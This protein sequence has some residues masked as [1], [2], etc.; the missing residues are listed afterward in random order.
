MISDGPSMTIGEY[1]LTEELSSGEIWQGINMKTNL[2]VAIKVEEVWT[3]KSKLFHEFKVYQ[4][5]LKDNVGLN[6]GIPNVYYVD[7]DGDFNYLVMD[8]LGPNLEDLFNRCQRK[9]SLK[10]VLMLADQML[11]RIEYLHNKKYIHRDIKPEN[12]VIGIGETSHVIHMID[13]GLA[14]RYIKKDGKHI[15]FRDDGDFIGTPRYGSINVHFGMT[16]GRRDDLQSL[17]YVLMYFLRGSLP[18]QNIQADE[19]HSKIHNIFRQKYCIIQVEDLCQGYPSEFATYLNYVRNLYF[20]VTPNYSY[21]RKLFKDLFKKSGF[22]M[23]YI[24]DWDLISLQDKEKN[25]YHASAYKDNTNENPGFINKVEDNSIWRI[26][27]RKKRGR[28]RNY[29]ATNNNINEES[30]KETKFKAKN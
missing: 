12:F 28:S 7:S 20:E 8:L 9:F 13:F 15:P 11:A 24:Y 17:A 16:P 23:D 30:K 14:K 4:C 29:D 21:L 19:I 25:E 22:E 5:L 10:T 3:T 6:K 1:K 27:G 26:V 18:W 2:K